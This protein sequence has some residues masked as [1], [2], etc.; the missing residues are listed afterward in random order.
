[1]KKVWIIT[2]FP[3]FFKPL[4][5]TGVVGSAMRG[6]RGP[7]P[8]LHFLNPS[9]FN[10]KGFKGVD[11]APYGGGAGQVMRADVLENTLHRGVYDGGDYTASLK[12]SLHICY[13][14]PRGETF[15]AQMAQ[16]M[17][18]N[19]LLNEGSKD[20]VFIC[21]RYEGIDERYIEAYVDQHI[22]LGDFVLSGGE[23]ALLPIID[24]ILRF[25]PG[26]LGNSVSAV[27]ESF[28]NGLLEY[29]QYTRPQVACGL[30][31]PA[32][33]SS[34]HHEKVKG[35]RD[36]QSLIMTRKYRPDLLR[37]SEKK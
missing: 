29:P 31:V 36:E 8:K 9:D 27:D 17:C 18:E 12:D 32:I 28:S 34:G 2:L 33:L 7:M 22:S 1:M 13:L 15:N 20:L 16:M 25:Y 10:D 4:F 26:V 6:E 35:W 24:A 11:A 19:Y 37:K 30:E 21:G 14:G 3:E 23:L 5:E